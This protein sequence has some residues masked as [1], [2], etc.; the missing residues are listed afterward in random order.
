METTVT[1]PG[2]GA[3]SG[4][5]ALSGNA[6]A[7]PAHFP[8]RPPLSRA[9]LESN[10]LPGSSHFG[11]VGPSAVESVPALPWE[12]TA[13][14]RRPRSLPAK[15]PLQRHFRRGRKLPSAGRPLGGL[16]GCPPDAPGVL[17]KDQVPQQF[18]SVAPFASLT[19]AAASQSPSRFHPQC[20]FTRWKWVPRRG[21]GV[22]AGGQ[23]AFHL[24]G[25]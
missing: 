12:L 5:R 19:C 21:R 15:G 14:G 11:P 9:A 13:T 10:R 7:R 4:G 18:R 1:L 8:L 25:I 3:R 23:E 17:A 6:P 24:G 20:L 2:G 16:T 22:S